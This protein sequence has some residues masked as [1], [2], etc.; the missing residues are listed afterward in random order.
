M[1]IYLNNQ[2]TTS[3]LNKVG[4]DA[5]QSHPLCRTHIGSCAHSHAMWSGCEANPGMV[6]SVKIRW[7]GPGYHVIKIECGE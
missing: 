3:P 7:G 2:Q 5:M 1:G 4:L 6:P